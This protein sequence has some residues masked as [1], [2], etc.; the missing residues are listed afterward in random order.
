MLRKRPNLLPF[1]S[2]SITFS[3]GGNH[4]ATTSR[5]QSRSVAET[6]FG[7]FHLMEY[8]GQ[9]HTRSP[10]RIS[11]RSHPAVRSNNSA[12][13]AYENYGQRCPAPFPLGDGEFLS[14]YLTLKARM[15]S[16]L[17]SF[18]TRAANFEASRFRGSCEPNMDAS[19]LDRQP[20]CPIAVAEQLGAL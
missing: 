3:F 19:Q 6:R 16:I 18:I 7:V 5:V 4:P 12:A 20:L 13:I 15:R 9:L 8:A 1:K 10:A 11:V 17:K 14:N 2:T